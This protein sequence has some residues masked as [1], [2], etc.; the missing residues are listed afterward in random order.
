MSVSEGW[1]GI[2]N[3]NNIS[4]NSM[5]SS[6]A[7]SVTCL[8]E[9]EHEPVYEMDE[10]MHTSTSCTW[11]LLSVSLHRAPT[12]GFGIAIS[13][14]LDNPHFTSGD[15]VVVISDVVQNGPA[16]GLLQVNDRILSGNNVSFENID[17]STAVDIIKNKDQIN[18]I[19]KR[20][21]AM[22][23]LEF[24]QR[25]LKFTLSKS[26][27]KDDFGIVVGCK[28]YIKEIRN[29]KLAEKDPGLR[30]GDSVLRINGQSLE[31]ATLEEVNKWLERS[32][33]K[34]CLVIQR[35][36][37][38]GTSRWP[39]QNTVYERVGGGSMNATPRHSPSPMMPHVPIQQRNSHEY[40]NSPRYRPDGSVERRVSS[41]ANSQISSTI[42]MSAS[43]IQQQQ[44][45][46]QQQNMITPQEYE[47][48]TRQSAKPQDQNGVRNVIFRKV[49][50][51][52]GVRVIGGNEVGIFVS[53]V[54]ADSPAAIHGVCCGDRILEVNGRN[55]RG[56]TR[57]SAV[58]LL[59]GLDDRV[60]LKLEH[61]RGEFEHVRSNQLGDNFYIRSHFTKE[62]KNSALE[63]S[64]NEGDI[65]H[66][67]D[68]LFGGTVGLW[69]AARVY[70][71][72]ENKG[73][74]VKGVIPNQA[75]A[76]IVAKEYRHF[77]EAKQQKTSGG[78]LLRRKFESR[79]SKSLP[80]N[81]ICDPT[82][83]SANIPLPA[84]ERVSLNTPS[85]HRPIV[86]FGPLADI[87]RQYLLQQFSARFGQPES[88]G[89]VIRLSSV[90]HVI[91][92]M[93]HCI[94][95]ISIESV[96]RL[97]LAQYA[98]IVVL[99]DVENRGR[100][101]EIRKRAN[102]PHLSSRKL[103]EHSAQIKKY[104][105]HLLSATIDATHENGW[106]DALRELIVHLQQ[107]RLWMPEF[108]PNL[109]LEDVLLFPLPKCDGDVDS[110]KS[111]YIEYN[112]SATNSM[113]RDDSLPRN[114]T[115]SQN[116][117]DIMKQS[118]YN[119]DT[120]SQAQVQHQAQTQSPFNST[121]IPRRF[122]QR[123]NE[124][125][126]SQGC[127]NATQTAFIPTSSGNSPVPF[128]QKAQPPRTPT[129]PGY[130]HVK[131]LLDDESLYQDARL[132]NEIANVRLREE[133]RLR[134]E[135][136]RNLNVVEQ[137]PSSLP[138]RLDDPTTTSNSFD[139]S[140]S[141]ST[142]T[143]S[144]ANQ[145]NTSKY[146]PLT[147][148]SMTSASSST[149]SPRPVL[150]PK[151]SQISNSNGENGSGG[152]YIRNRW[153]GSGNGKD[154]EID[155]RM[156]GSAS[157]ANGNENE[158]GN[159][160]EKNEEEAE[161]EEEEPIVVEEATAII[162]FAG[163]IIRCP[164]SNVELR[165]PEGAVKKGEKHE[166]YVKVCREG[167]ISPIDR[168]KGETLLSPLVMCGPQGLKFDKQCEL[169]MPH[170]GPIQSE[171]ESDSGQWSFS[172]KTG[173]GGEWK[174][175]DIEQ[176]KNKGD[177]HQFLTVPITHF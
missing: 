22:P 133:A 95:D 161:N 139:F 89:G 5:Y 30:E 173:E 156:N 154:I 120:S 48:Y 106:F 104:H 69:Q 164:N 27:K 100:I 77:I 165:I 117:Q 163:G 113:R 44:L 75:T 28:F 116:Q 142:N 177:E 84:Y 91:A 124:R 78:T 67:T 21:V 14:G 45:G 83:L 86:L 72:A 138:H 6:M 66:V 129:S 158:N 39:S 40:V 74:P 82:E 94:L 2:N 107:R 101:R 61:A 125:N 34:L 137:S 80:K 76:E 110:L 53:A 166:I 26:R 1:N 25:T 54:A 10:E 71:S 151:P 170:T 42:G 3:Q 98:P 38:R 148:S 65:F 136:A 126:G 11:Q 162:D 143:S 57:E 36:V 146:H 103:A 55:M 81:M 114:G 130:Y 122:E 79:K 105:S 92:S 96:E 135:K 58:Q 20:R 109:P 23:M 131:Q 168:S 31:G 63:L 37:K 171:N 7:S 90:D 68:T 24:E 159:E 102:A 52:V 153:P 49:G 118:I 73:E 128:A 145:P 144:P 87:A 108:P 64:V 32:R 115:P 85:F 70:S 33:D 150:P 59:L 157:P 62:K 60:S 15:P 175:M 99:L 121:T 88:D 140:N 119:W 152:G 13:G 160:H 35:D 147:P 167:E 112:N 155:A 50:G 111:E 41:P 19:V 141:S 4:N 127:L 149:N 16:W 132:A 9:N 12:L 123:Q 43:T 8:A 169:R 174:H 134:D 47:Y 51:S 93:K 18:M 97:Q 46:G 29:P 17:Y 176:T 56:I 172:L